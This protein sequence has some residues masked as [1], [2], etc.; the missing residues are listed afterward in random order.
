M[1]NF[2][3]KILTVIKKNPLGKSGY[4]W[5]PR[6]IRKILNIGPKEW[7]KLTTQMYSEQI[8]FDKPPNP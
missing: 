3:Q 4:G 7:R 5:A 8:S 1:K 2:E 6:E